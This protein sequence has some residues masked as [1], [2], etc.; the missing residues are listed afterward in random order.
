MTMFHHLHSCSSAFG[1]QTVPLATTK[2][3][4]ACH[5]VKHVDDTFCGREV[6][7]STGSHSVQVVIH[8]HFGMWQGHA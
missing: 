6:A 7:S 5:D 4:K 3:L 1:Q 2:Y 8:M